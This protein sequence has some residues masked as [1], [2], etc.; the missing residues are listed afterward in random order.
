MDRT[1]LLPLS[2]SSVGD[3]GDLCF[4]CCHLTSLSAVTLLILPLFLSAFCLTLPN[5]SLCLLT[6]FS[7]KS[8]LLVCNGLLHSAMVYFAIHFFP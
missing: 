3:L 1:F 5:F 2:V 6:Q 4:N 7:A 8:M